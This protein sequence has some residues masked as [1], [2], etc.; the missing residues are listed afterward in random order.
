MEMMVRRV[1]MAWFDWRQSNFFQHKHLRVS[2]DSP[3]HVVLASI[4]IVVWRNR[5]MIRFG[6]S[7]FKKSKKRPF[8]FWFWFSPQMFSTPN[9]ICKLHSVQQ[10][11]TGEVN[12][13]DQINMAFKKCGMYN[14]IDGSEN[15]LVKVKG[16]KDYKP[17]GKE[18]AKEWF[19]KNVRNQLLK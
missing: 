13:Q 2:C 7:Q 16:A 3:K 12:H 18:D 5:V 15:H 17:P 11:R 6:V 10:V 4:E 9:Q 8:L 1:R 14:A 19:A